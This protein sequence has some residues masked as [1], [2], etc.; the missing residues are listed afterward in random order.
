MDRKIERI[1]RDKVWRCLEE[2]IRDEKYRYIKYRTKYK[3]YSLREY[4]SESEVDV[5]AKKL[6]ACFNQRVVIMR[7]DTI[8]DVVQNITKNVRNNFNAL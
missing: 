8:V 2:S 3:T 5:L 7:K 4:W 6:R 1:I